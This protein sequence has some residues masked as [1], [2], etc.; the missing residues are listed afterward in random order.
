M[1]QY[2]V[3][4]LHGPMASWGTNAPGEVR[5]SHELPTRS[6]LLGLLAAALGIRRDEEARLNDFNRHYSFLVCASQNPRWARDYHTVQ[7]PREVRNARYFCRREELSDPELLSALISRRDYYTD[8]WWM[9]ALAQ[10]P[11]APYSLEQLWD[12][13]RHPVFPLYLGR[14]SHPLALPLSPLLLEGCAPDVLNEAY[15][16]YRNKFRMLKL[17]LATLHAECWW[18]GEHDGLN[19]N[20]IL[21]HRDRPINR[22]QWLFGERVV[23]QGPLFIQ[24]ETCISQK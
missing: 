2:L 24:E 15:Q 19:A 9:V 8:A 7:V 20:K 23:N 17:P 6:A 14:K 10:T 5:H 3:F 21:R 11:D 13:L 18:E 12:A 1:S 16:H 22:Q 4:Q